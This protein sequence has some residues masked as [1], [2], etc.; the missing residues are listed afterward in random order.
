MQLTYAVTLSRTYRVE[1]H[2]RGKETDLMVDYGMQE[3]WVVLHHSISLKKCQEVPSGQSRAES[4]ILLYIGNNQLLITFAFCFLLLT[5]S[6][7][8]H[9]ST[10]T[11][12]LEGKYVQRRA[13][14]YNHTI[15]LPL[16][17]PTVVSLS[18]KEER[19]RK[20]IVLVFLLPALT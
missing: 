12:K 4:R 11:N 19:S 20:I 17:R 13:L 16:L 10:N 7:V 8:L 15:F 18:S 5:E 6:Q 14:K 1:M 3:N 9:R 2:Q